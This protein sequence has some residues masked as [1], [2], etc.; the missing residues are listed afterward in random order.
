MTTKEADQLEK[1]FKTSNKTKQMLLVKLLGDNKWII[2]EQINK[3]L[4]EQ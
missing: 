4:Y 3:L 2:N 1:V